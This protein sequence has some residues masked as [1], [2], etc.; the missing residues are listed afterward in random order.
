MVNGRPD[1]AVDG[2]PP[3][4]VGISF[5]NA[6]DYLLDAVRSVFAQTHQDWELI[7]LNDGSKDGSLE[8]ARSID[9]ARVRVYSDTRNKG[10]AAR[11]NELAH[12]ARYEFL[13]RMDA[14]DLMS[15]H[16][17]ER[18]LRLLMSDSRADL[19]AT[20]L[21]SL[22]ADGEPVGVRG[23]PNDHQI[24]PYRLLTG[25]SG[26][27]HASV[28]GRRQ[29]FLRNPYDESLP[30]SQDMNLWVRAFAKGDLQV[31]FIPAP[32]YF[33]RED[34]NVTR[35]KLLMSYR[36]ARRTIL[37]DAGCEFRYSE[38]VRAMARYWFNSAA[39]QIL[40]ATGRLGLL[41]ARR[42]TTALSSGERGA[43][44]REIDAIRAQPLPV[45]PS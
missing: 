13:A 40:G 26:I 9:D 18:Q 38:R 14:D 8:I 21:Y 45:R 5:Y 15:R 4:S 17:L 39:V 28:L 11:L 44:M 33:Y 10:L 7:L 42:N 25:N 36:V 32:L 19:V 35:E 29:W 43:V 3:I 12:L 1:P 41:R 2:L 37:R 23:V 24:V 34:G 27:L 22:R 30:R 31:R 16:R 6:K 20:G